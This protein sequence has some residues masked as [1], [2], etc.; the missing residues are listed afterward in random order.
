MC[1]WCK[2]RAE[3]PITRQ[4][5]IEFECHRF[6]HTKRWASQEQAIAVGSN[7]PLIK[8]QINWERYLKEVKNE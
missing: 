1:Q 8:Y 2:G 5:A 7:K 3:P 4:E 6:A